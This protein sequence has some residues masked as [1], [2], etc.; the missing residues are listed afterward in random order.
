MIGTVSLRGILA[1]WFAMA[2]PLGAMLLSAPAQ[3]QVSL[4]TAVD[5]ARRNSAPVRIAQADVA[6]AQA[7]LSE[8]RD[9][10]LPSFSAG[11]SVGYT[12]GFPVG[13]PTLFNG[14]AQSLVV[15]FSQ[16]DYIRAARAGLHAA[17]LSLQDALDQV[18]LDASLDYLQLDTITQQLVALGEQKSYAEK[19][20]QVEEARLSA[21]VESQIAA[22]KAE[23]NGSRADLKRLDLE[24]QA[25]VLRERL[26]HLAG[27][28]AD[29]FRT[30][31]ES[32]PGAPP[33]LD[34][35][36]LPM[37]TSGVQAAFSDAASKHYLAR[38][39]DRQILR[40]QA[41]FGVQ[42]SRFAM[43]NNYRQ[44]YN[45]F[46]HNN[47]DVG[48]QLTIPLFDAVK[49][50]HARQSAADA[51]HADTQA[52]QDRQNAD[53]QVVQLRKSLATLRAQAKI[54]DLEAQ[55]ASQQLQSVLLQLASPPASATPLT[56][57]DEMQARINERARFSDALDA[58]FALLKAE[59]SLLRVTGGLHAWV[60]TAARQ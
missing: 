54:A 19:L 16:P 40:P 6:R 33:N 43:F 59:L 18:E 24:A 15:S 23:L 58:R 11:S 38:G 45:A 57:A 30:K 2:G 27:L 12:Y 36:A 10:Y 56:P 60:D 34:R 9:V 41:A 13:Q 49:T 47:F 37:Q 5:L 7:S 21:G 3:A 39:D 42:Y 28:P 26:S 25:A 35:T 51:V 22:T 17:T 29:S 14:Q 44:Y 52:E 46:Q 55:L 1:V 20:E 48:I 8:T 4:Y 53:E 31:P 32:V 50:A